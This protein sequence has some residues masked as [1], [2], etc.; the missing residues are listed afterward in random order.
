MQ[1]THEQTHKL[2]QRKMDQALNSQESAA[3]SMHLQHCDDCQQYA[4]EIREVDRLLFPVLKKHW[5]RQPLPL[6]A[7]TLMGTSQKTAMINL[8][9]MRK[10]AVSLAALTLFFG[11]WQFVATG[12]SAFSQIPQMI[13]P[14]PTPSTISTNTPATLAQCEMAL[15]IVQANDTISGISDRFAISVE[16]IMEMNQLRTEV[17]RP[18]MELIIPLCN[19]TPTGTV[20]PA[21]FT[22]T[23]TPILQTIAFTPDG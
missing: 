13:P 17:I 10:M 22:T 6:S 5:D 8:L 20:H 23:Y 16:E 7:S 15:Y 11:V 3:L 19:F 4:N 18:A 21:T 2:I 12:P 1:I 14:V 9:T